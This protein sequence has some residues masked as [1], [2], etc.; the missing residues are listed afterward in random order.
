MII[1]L[2]VVLYAL[3]G[4]GEVWLVGVNILIGDDD[5]GTCSQA[6]MLHLSLAD[7][8]LPPARSQH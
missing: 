1:V 8:T 5:G 7:N 2:T 3:T 4:G 6:V